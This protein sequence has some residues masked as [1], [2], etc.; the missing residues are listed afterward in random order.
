M[1]TSRHLRR[2]DAGALEG[3]LDGGLAQFVRGQTRESAVEGPDRRPCGADD[4]DIVFHG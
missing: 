1:M 3:L 4:D 2:L